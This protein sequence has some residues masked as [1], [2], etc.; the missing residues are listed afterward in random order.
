MLVEGE[1]VAETAGTEEDGVEEVLVCF[2]A[3]AETFAGT[4]EV[5]KLVD[6]SFWA[7]SGTRSHG[8]GS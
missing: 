4:I 6:N 2:V 8:S 7:V 3:V 5:G 1:T